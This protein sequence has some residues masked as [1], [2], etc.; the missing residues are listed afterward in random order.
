MSHSDMHHHQS[1]C[2]RPTW[3][4]HHWDS[5]P[6][7]VLYSILYTRMRYRRR[8]TIYWRFLYIL[9]FT[10]SDILC[11]SK[12]ALLRIRSKSAYYTIFFDGIAATVY[13]YYSISAA[14]GCPLLDIFRIRGWRIYSS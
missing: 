4:L 5:Q 12:L 7:Y 8:C 13:V 2:G 10:A 9:W 14:Y 6:E 1:L 11:Y 3:T